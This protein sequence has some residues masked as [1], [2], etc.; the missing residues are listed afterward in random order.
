MFF[1]KI[2]IPYLFILLF[3]PYHS[4]A[5]KHMYF[6][7]GTNMK[8]VSFIE[9][10]STLRFSSDNVVSINGEILGTRGSMRFTEKYMVFPSIIKSDKGDLDVDIYLSLNSSNYNCI[11][12]WGNNILE[13]FKLIK[14]DFT[15]YNSYTFKQ[16]ESKKN[17]YLNNLSLKLETLEDDLIKT[18][19][20]NEKTFLIKAI[21]NSYNRDYKDIFQND[22]AQIKKLNESLIEITDQIK[23]Q[24]TE[25]ISQN[26]KLDSLKIF[27]VRVVGLSNSDKIVDT[28]MV[29][30]RASSLIFH[31]LYKD[32]SIL[33]K[34]YIDSNFI[35]QFSKKINC[36]K[37]L[38]SV[39]IDETNY[40]QICE[41]NVPL[42]DFIS[43][44]QNFGWNLPSSNLSN[45]TLYRKRKL[46]FLKIKNSMQY[47]TSLE[48]LIILLLNVLKAMLKNLNCLM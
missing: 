31:T 5:Q 43:L 48:T 9:T 12:D 47:A 36:I 40:L 2:F 19:D 27:S 24:K 21:L 17:K 32:S 11:I 13:Q 4:W 44:G 10:G 46:E 16:I 14:V 20:L 30:N 34:K 25:V 45:P 7:K 15:S 6:V 18:K 8:T 42:L 29:I 37:L 26:K 28:F 35:S 33:L 38:N 41:L 39:N 23:K 1:S 22:P 3:T